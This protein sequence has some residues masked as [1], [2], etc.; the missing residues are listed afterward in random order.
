MKRLAVL[1]ASFLAVIPM[2]ASADHGDARTIRYRITEA[3]LFTDGPGSCEFSGTVAIEAIDGQVLGTTTLCVKKVE[4]RFGP[5]YQFIER[6]RLVVEL[7]DG[8]LYIKVTFTDTYNSDFT[9]AAH[10]ARGTINRGTGR[11]DGATGTLRGSGPILF[12]SDGT[13]QPF[14]TYRVK[15]DSLVP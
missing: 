5:P 9:S 3:P 14:L 2:T 13:P 1:L 8:A 7:P 6:G 4:E 15:L 10:D 12:D 11:Y